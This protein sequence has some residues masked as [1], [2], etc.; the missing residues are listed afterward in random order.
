MKHNFS[1]QVTQNFKYT[2]SF[3]NYS[4][5]AHNHWHTQ[6]FTL[7][8]IQFFLLHSKFEV[9]TFDDPVKAYIN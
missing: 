2:H 8:V 4:N 1:V 5:Q 3:I 9:R 7:T 6:Q